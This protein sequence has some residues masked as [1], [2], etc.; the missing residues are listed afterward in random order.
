[1]REVRSSEL[2]TRASAEW[3]MR[4]AELWTF[5]DQLVEAFHRNSLWE[6]VEILPHSELPAPHCRRTFHPAPHS[7]MPSVPPNDTLRA[8]SLRVRRTAS[9]TPRSELPTLHCRR[10]F[11]P[12]PHSGMPSVPPNETLRAT[13]LRV[14]RAASSTPHSP[15]RTPHFLEPSPH[16]IVHEQRLDIGREVVLAAGGHVDAAKGAELPPGANA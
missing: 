11:H 13:S 1:M 4:S 16:L 14:R 10:T 8:T 5:L 3:G 9:S 7:G 2:W 12:A 15:L 6:F